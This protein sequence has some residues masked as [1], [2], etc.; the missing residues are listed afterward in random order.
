ME[1]TSREEGLI[2]SWY[3]VKVIRLADQSEG[4]AC[5]MVGGERQAL[6]Q[7]VSFPDT[8]EEVCRATD[9]CVHIRDSAC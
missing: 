1:V 7:Y 4:S 3:E 9:H 5:E 2:G 6:V 8:S